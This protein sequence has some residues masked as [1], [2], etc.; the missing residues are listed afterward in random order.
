MSEQDHDNQFIF[1]RFN[2]LTTEKKMAAIG[3]AISSDAEIPHAIFNKLLLSETEPEVIAHL[4]YVLEQ[5]GDESSV[6][7]LITLM[8]KTDSAEVC[9]EIT[10]ALLRRNTSEAIG[11]LREV[12]SGKIQTACTPE[13]LDSIR[14]LL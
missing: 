3:A 11:F 2:E 1:S 4:A 10:F 12:L 5:F 9:I 8:R 7:P 13:F 14:K 6:E